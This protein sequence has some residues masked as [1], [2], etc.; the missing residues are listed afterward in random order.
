M[1]AVVATRASGGSTGNPGQPCAQPAR[2]HLAAVRV[3]AG[4]ASV[5]AG[6]MVSTQLLAR[7][8]YPARTAAHCDARRAARRTRPADRQHRGR[9]EDL[10]HRLARGSPTAAQAT[11]LHWQGIRLP[12]RMD[13]L[14]RTLVAAFPNRPPYGGQFDGSVPRLTVGPDG[15]TDE[16]LQAERE[17]Q[18]KLPLRAAAEAVTLMAELPSGRWERRSVFT[19]AK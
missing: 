9:L 7:A 13:G 1:S 2:P 4:G 8:R 19:L 6:R 17:L 15:A 11:T 16:L 3:G 5:P 10:V 12:A 14:T 18:A